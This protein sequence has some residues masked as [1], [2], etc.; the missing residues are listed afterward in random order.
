MGKT[1]YFYDRENK[2][3]G[4]KSEFAEEEKSDWP[5][6]SE[7]NGRYQ[8]MVGRKLSKIFFAS[9]SSKKFSKFQEKVLFWVYVCFIKEF[10]EM[11]QVCVCFGGSVKHI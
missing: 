4:E 6:T 2:C 9:A 1:F 11:L 3:R 7:V 10:Y 5:Q 8:S